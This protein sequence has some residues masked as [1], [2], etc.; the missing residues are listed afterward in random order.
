MYSDFLTKTA[1]VKRLGTTTKTERSRTTVSGT[2]FNVS[3]VQ[4]RNEMDLV[5]GMHVTRYMVYTDF[6]ST[7]RKGDTITV[8][9]D[10]YIVLVSEPFK[11]RGLE[12][13]RLITDRDTQ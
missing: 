7:I 6:D 5:Q 4:L 8:D 13:R 11:V 2:T 12:F 1:T 10:D 9:N 3:E